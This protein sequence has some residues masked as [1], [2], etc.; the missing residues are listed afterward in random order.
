M[1]ASRVGI[2][3]EAGQRVAGSP[4]QA[5]F[6]AGR[7]KARTTDEIAGAASTWLI[8][9]NRIND[10]AFAADGRLAWERIR[11]L[12]LAAGPD[13]DPAPAAAGSSG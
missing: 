13:G 3:D 12:L 6:Q 4:A 8:D 7:E 2:V 10:T 5:A 9:I 11:P 1:T